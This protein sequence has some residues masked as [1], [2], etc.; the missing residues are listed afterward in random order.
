LDVALSADLAASAAEQAGRDAADE[1]GPAQEITSAAPTTCS[2]ASSVEAESCAA[3]NLAAHNP[4][5]PFSGP[6]QG[7]SF[8]ARSSARIGHR[9]AS[10]EAATT[11]HGAPSG[12]DSEQLQPHAALANGPRAELSA[13]ALQERAAKVLIGDGERPAASGDSPVASTATVG[14]VLAAKQAIESVWA[15]SAADIK[16]C[17]SPSMPLG[18]IDAQE[19]FGFLLNDALGRPLLPHD[20]ARGVGQAGDNAVAAAMGSGKGPRRRKGKLEKARDAAREAVRKARHAVATD[21]ALLPRITAAEAA[22]K[23]AV[24]AVLS[25]P[26]DLKLPN[27]TVG[28]RKRQRREASSAAAPVPVAAPVVAEAAAVS[29]SASIAQL[30]A[31]VAAD[32]CRVERAQRRLDA[33]G[34]FDPP[35]PDMSLFCPKFSRSCPGPW[36]GCRACIKQQQAFTAA[37]EQAHDAARKPWDL[38]EAA[39]DAATEELSLSREQLISA[40]KQACERAQSA[41]KEARLREL[42]DLRVALCESRVEALLWQRRAHEMAIEVCNLRAKYGGDSDESISDSGDFPP[43]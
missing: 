43:W 9:H 12:R 26:V 30:E 20:A 10:T 22:G 24:A 13:A 19:A 11:S 41:L 40:R 32:E 37:R 16:R 18:L 17:C 15:E 5:L 6:A 27:A 33:L 14:F 23:A 2:S 7:E 42:Q 38:A 29:P 21:P 39:V 31:V 25:A 1:S 28:A 3:R 36:G 34:K 4:E 35:D 8:C